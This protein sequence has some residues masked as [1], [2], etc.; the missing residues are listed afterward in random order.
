VKKTPKTVLLR[1]GRLVDGTGASDQNP[2]AIRIE[3]NLIAE[4]GHPDAVGVPE[5]AEVIDLG[6][7]TILPGM[8]DA[9]MHFFG[10]PS[11]RMDHLG[12]EVEAYRALRA[13][14][15]ARRMLEAGITSARCLGSGIS[16]SLRRAINEGH[17]PGP[18]LVTA[19]EFICST[20]GTWAHH[21]MGIPVDALKAEMI[22]DGVEG[23]QQVVR[24]RVRQGAN[25]IKVGISD[26]AVDDEF[27]GWGND[28]YRQTVTY[29]LEEIR[30]LASEAHR[31]ALK[32]SAHCIGDEAVRAA[33]AGGV[34]VI[35]HGHGINDETRKMIVDKGTVVV[36]TLSVMR[37]SHDAPA[38]HTP[39][40]HI[41]VF[42]QRHIDAQR[43]ALEKGLEAGI[44]FAA[45]SDLYGYPTVP[46]DSAAREFELLVEYGMDP[47]DAIVSGTQIGSEVLGFDRLVGSIEK[48]KL[49]DFIA[50]D[51]DPLRAIAALKNVSFVMS[52]GDVILNRTAGE[53]RATN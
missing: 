12:D 3:G 41:R 40:D 20:R 24:R 10:V 38:P 22:A 1:A 32:V 27:F 17:V 51:E 28:P 43:E 26:G 11:D 34:D 19:G 36:T 2:V 6:D 9:H 14:G 5:E 53:E 49:A 23:V 13:A 46:Q 15:E 47:M 18:R 50:V 52:D 39:P 37:T 8:I 30:S 45:G 21:G 4:I 7:R 29:S 25:V 35:E 31:H 42:Q 48:G 16:P 33:L 44:R